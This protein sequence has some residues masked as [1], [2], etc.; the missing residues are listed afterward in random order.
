M[1]ALYDPPGDNSPS[2]PPTS[3]VLLKFRVDKTD[4][5]C[6]TIT[7]DPTSGGVVLTNPT[8]N[9]DVNAP[10]SGPPF[11]TPKFCFTPSECLIG[12][13][14]ALSEKTDWVAWGKPDCWCYQYQCRG[15][16][17]GKKTGPYRVQTADLAV[18]AAA[19]NKLDAQLAAIPNG[20]CA[21]L[22]H[23]K[24]GP[25]RVQT[26]DLAELAKYFNKL[27]ASVPACNVAPLTTGP[28]NFWKVP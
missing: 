4:N 16:I 21:D 8:L 17:N 3:G 6:V 26:A 1:G 10:G 25:Y 20:I 22:N 27:D 12:G 9:P 18:L 14:A 2:A 15:D 19:F 11:N 24:T 23:K 7:E 28:Y 13:I 5:V